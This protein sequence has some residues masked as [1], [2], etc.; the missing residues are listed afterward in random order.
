MESG[1]KPDDNSNLPPLISA[2][3]IDSMSSGDESD[4]EPSSTDML[5]DICDNNQYCL[6]INSREARYKIRGHIKQGQA[7]WKRALLSTR[8]MG[9]GLHTVF[10]AVVN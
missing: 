6:S 7:G 9:K 4:S 2:E 10:K 5:E 8:N 3:E 1:N